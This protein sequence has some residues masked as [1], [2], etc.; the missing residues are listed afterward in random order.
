ML[1]R[2][3]KACADVEFKFNSIVEMNETYVGELQKYKQA[4][5]KLNTGR[6]T[7]GIK[8]EMEAKERKGRVVA[9]PILKTDRKTTTEFAKEPAVAGATVYTNGSKIYNHLSNNDDSA[10]HS[11]KQWI[12]GKVNIIRIENI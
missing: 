12:E 6:G 3:R 1:H 11:E 4:D 8:P 2:I 9:K 10:K 7:L 5:K